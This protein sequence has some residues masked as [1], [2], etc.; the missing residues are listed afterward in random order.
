MVRERNSIPGSPR[1]PLV[2]ANGKAS[3]AANSTLK[4][5]RQDGTIDWETASESKALR[6]GFRIEYESSN[7]GK[8]QTNGQGKGKGK[9]KQKRGRHDTAGTSSGPG[10][11][12]CQVQTSPFEDETLSAIRY[13]VEPS[14]YW[15]AAQPY[16]RCTSKSTLNLACTLQY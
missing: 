7:G 15:E 6:D 16:S 1:S 14:T 9:K 8:K 12:D 11:H 13:R 3:D 2:L 4:R 10:G 5:K